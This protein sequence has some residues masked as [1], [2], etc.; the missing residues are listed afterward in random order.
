VVNTQKVLRQLYLPGPAPSAWQ[1][2]RAR[3]RA[4]F[5]EWVARRSWKLAAASLCI[6]AWIFGHLHYYNT[7]TELEFN[8]LE[9]RAQIEAQ[10]Q[11]RHHIRQNLMALVRGYTRYEER[12][13]TALTELRTGTQSLPLPMGEAPSLSPHT[14]LGS[15]PSSAPSAPGSAPSV[16][17]AAAPQSDLRELLSQV[18][19]VGEQYPDLKLTQ[20]LQQISAS[21][22]DSET[23]I[24]LRIMKYNDAVNVYGTVLDTFPGKIFGTLSGFKK[25]EFHRVDPEKRQYQEVSF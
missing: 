12:L 23:E 22:I 14:G 21:I 17:S 13:L 1:R 7:L 11:R 10:E 4:S 8:V 5:K 2:R 25:H 20:N 3:M 18:R 9:A 19:I 15:A 16:L 6:A 24:S